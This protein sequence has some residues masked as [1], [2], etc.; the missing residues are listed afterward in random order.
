MIYQKNQENGNIHVQVYVFFVQTFI[1]QL[2]L[3]THNTTSKKR[4][5]RLFVSSFFAF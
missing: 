1:L 3:T 2:G 4:K 5:D